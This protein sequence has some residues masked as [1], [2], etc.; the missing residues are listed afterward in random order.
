MVNHVSRFKTQPPVRLTWLLL[1]ILFG[2]CTPESQA[3]TGV[4][5]EQYFGA[6]KVESVEQ[7]RGGLTS[8][9]QAQQRIGRMVLVSAEKMIS[10]FASIENPRYEVKCYP[11][12]PEGEVPNRK[13][14]TFYGLGQQRES[15]DVLQVYA[16][17]DKEGE[18]SYYFEIIEGGLWELFDGWVYQLEPEG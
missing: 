11:N 5:V 3:C 16:E 9:E 1:L 17:G 12:T 6:Y 14:S 15:V 8:A 2:G 13:L 7:Y 4:P 10:D 18:P